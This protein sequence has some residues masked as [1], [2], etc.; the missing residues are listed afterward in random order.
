MPE[1]CACHVIHPIYS[2]R[3]GGVNC[4]YFLEAVLPANENLHTR[5]WAEIRRALDEP[6]DEPTKAC[7]KCGKAFIPNGNRQKYCSVCGAEAEKQKRRER[8]RKK[9]WADQHP[10]PSDALEAENHTTGTQS[11]PAP[12]SGS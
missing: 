10:I 9:Y 5:V 2:I 12:Q 6:V 4:D 11:P 8:Q 7:V 1:D 3:D